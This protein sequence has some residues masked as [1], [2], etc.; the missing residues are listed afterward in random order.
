[1]TS[2]KMF[3]DRYHFN[4]MRIIAV[5]YH[6]Y[7]ENELYKL[8]YRENQGWL[9]KMGFLIKQWVSVKLIVL[10]QGLLYSKVLD[11]MQNYNIIYYLFIYEYIPH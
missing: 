8:S 7:I 1:M 2:F 10:S 9:Y 6:I 4:I 11:Y 3:S 5:I